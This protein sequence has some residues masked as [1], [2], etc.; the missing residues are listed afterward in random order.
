MGAD[1]RRIHWIQQ[2]SGDI[3]SFTANQNWTQRVWNQGSNT[4]GSGYAT[5]LLGALSSGSSNYPLY[6][7]FRQWY[8]SPYIQDDWKATR[9][10][11]LN[12]GLRWDYNGPPDEKYNRLNRGFD[13]NAPSPLASQIPAAMLTQYPQLK[14]LKGG[15]L[16]AGVNGQPR[17]AG[18]RDFNNIQ[19][20]FGAAFQVTQKLIMRGGFGLYYA[21]PNNN[22]LQT[23]GFATSTTLVTSLDG[24]R[25]PIAHVLSNPYPN[26]INK[27]AGA[28]EGLLTF[29]GRNN[30]WFDPSFRTPRVHQ[31]SFGFQYQTSNASTLELTYVGSR[32]YGLNDEKDFNLPTS[33]FRRACNPLEGG[34]VS[35]CDAGLTNPF[36]GIEAFSGTTYFSANTISRY[37]LNRA[38]PQFSGNLLQQG[39]STS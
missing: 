27:P 2:N 16:F 19:P 15:F 3:L 24:G 33:T 39:L 18:D 5:F 31:F 35:F 38:Y 32:S 25:T 34:S 28:A 7:F 23:A 12:L 30:N 36:K 26:G 8:F 37:N 22:Y 17:G 1:L 29:V 6:P 20:R 11:T 9:R 10:L 14:S 21:N 13:A 4:E